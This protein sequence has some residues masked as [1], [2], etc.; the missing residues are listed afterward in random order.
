[1]ALRLDA[2][3]RHGQDADDPRAG[4]LHARDGVAIS[5]TGDLAQA[6]ERVRLDAAGVWLQ[7]GAAF[8]PAAALHVAAAEAGGVRGETLR[9]GFGADPLGA[10]MRQGT[11]PVPLARALGDMAD[12]ASG[13]SP[14]RQA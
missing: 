1:M 8:L 12:L 7:A 3:A 6:L 14:T 11:L 4:D 10:L 13:P 5:S 2:A 9:G